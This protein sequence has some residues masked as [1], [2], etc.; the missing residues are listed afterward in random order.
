MPDTFTPELMRTQR[1]YVPAVDPGQLGQALMMKLQAADRMHAAIFNSIASRKEPPNAPK[2]WLIQRHWDEVQARKERYAFGAFVKVDGKWVREKATWQDNLWGTIAD[3]YGNNSVGYFWSHDTPEEYD[4]RLRKIFFWLDPKPV[5][6]WWTPE[7]QKQIMGDLPDEYQTKVLTRAVSDRHATL[8]ADQYRQELKRGQRLSEMGWPGTIGQFA[9]SALDP[10]NVAFATF[11]GG[12]GASWVSASRFGRMG[13][14]M[15]AGLFNVPAAAVM[16]VP[17]MIYDP[18]YDVSTAAYSMSA[19]F[20]FGAAFGAAFDP[21]RA[22]A[23][24]AMKEQEL[25]DIV[26]AGAKLTAKGEKYYADVRPL[27][28]VARL[29][30]ASAQ[31]IAQMN[32]IIE[33]A[34]GM[35]G[36]G[37]KSHEAIE[38][39]LRQPGKLGDAIITEAGLR[40]KTPFGT[41]PLIIPDIVE[42]APIAPPAAKPVT[43]TVKPQGTEWLRPMLYTEAQKARETAKM[44][45]APAQKPTAALPSPKAAAALQAPVPT[46]AEVVARPNAAFDHMPFVAQTVRKWYKGRLQKANL[47]DAISDAMTHVATKWGQYDP[48]KEKPTTWMG[49]VIKNHLINAGER[50]KTEKAALHSRK[51]APLP[52]GAVLEPDEVALYDTLNSDVRAAVDELTDVQKKIA[53]SRLMADDKA[54]YRALSKQL[55]I[56]P[57]TVR[58]YEKLAKEKL[59][60]SLKKYIPIAEGGELP[61]G[62]GA[63][64]MHWAVEGKDFVDAYLDAVGQVENMPLG[65]EYAGPRGW[66]GILS[67]DLRAKLGQGEPAQRGLARR[68]AGNLFPDETGATHW[69]SAYEGLMLNRAVDAMKITYAY[70]P[71]FTAF[72]KRMKARGLSDIDIERTLNQTCA[73]AANADPV[74]LKAM[75]EAD[76]EIAD[77]VK[78]WKELDNGLWERGMRQKL[79]GFTPENRIDNYLMRSWRQDQLLG[80]FAEHGEDY[81]HAVIVKGLMNETPELNPKLADSF[82]NALVKNTLSRG[83]DGE[84][85]FWRFKGSET[86]MLRNILEN[87]GHNADEAT[88]MI[89]AWNAAKQNKG[90]VKGR[91]MVDYWAEIPGKDGK[92]LRLRDL[93]DRDFNNLTRRTI[94][95]FWGALMEWRVRTAYAEY[96]DTPTPAKTGIIADWTTEQGGDWMENWHVPE[97]RQIIADAN[98]RALWSA[99]HEAKTA[100]GKKWAAFKQRNQAARLE[101]MHRLVLG[102]PAHP[103]P[104]SEGARVALLTL[105]RLRKAAT[106]V[107]GMR[108]G[109]AQLPDTA[110]MQAEFG[111]AAF[112][113]QFPALMSLQRDA[114]SG[115]LSNATLSG[116]E[117]LYACDTGWGHFAHMTPDDWVSRP[118]AALG[119]VDRWLDQAHEATLKWSGFRAIDARQKLGIRAVI[120]QR[121]LDDAYGGQRI[122]TKRLGL[123]GWSESDYDQILS[124]MQEPGAVEA[125]AGPMTG[126]RFIKLNPENW[127]NPTAFAKLYAGVQ[128]GAEQSIIEPNPMML[129]SFMSGELARSFLQFRFFNLAAWRQHLLRGVYLHDAEAISGAAMSYFYGGLIGTGIVYS[130]ALGRPDKEEYLKRYMT[131]RS[132]AAGAFQRSGWSSIMPSLIDAS[133]YTLGQDPIFANTY[134]TTGLQTFGIA[135]TPSGALI[136]GAWEAESGAMKAMTRSDTVFSQQNA[137]QFRRMMPWSNMFLFSNVTNYGIGHSGLPPKS[138]VPLKER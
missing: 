42:G 134:R 130:N 126:R 95:N 85:H 88:S 102:M 97:M 12:F 64:K 24:K 70:E 114:L 78:A 66:L 34:N 73:D 125:T 16:D 100:V 30:K 14:A 124:A 28:E 45:P 46:A 6:Q 117:A 133:A 41:A 89:N 49:K 21:Y 27:P 54:T 93:L 112:N 40:A 71:A 35:P 2:D 110:F 65:R 91:M 115:K 52:R 128:R 26:E 105:K 57:E 120:L 7:I 36:G 20:A 44:L 37:F 111:P 55:G 82:A 10:A 108:F 113:K 15:R 76:P 22:Q 47:D 25:S 96:I 9:A 101:T 131:P 84:N 81:V 3:L 29:Q 94:N 86:E 61:G 107:F 8:I 56:S 5:E 79:A 118:E 116:I 48:S 98:K 38:A 33:E 19:A 138:A 32:R 121:V 51:A 67:F 136:Q 83:L 99:L 92:T 60:I 74:R 1:E 123:M 4:A 90:I 63:Q 18:H 80:A 39:S 13:R 43:G 87:A 104:A 137:Q 127:K 77:V 72:R 135:S 122:S 119:R 11:T 106:V 17:R 23:V 129:S 50:I 132:L 59:A 58:T 62:P 53:L 69:A 109:A 75:I 103:E 31:N 68:L